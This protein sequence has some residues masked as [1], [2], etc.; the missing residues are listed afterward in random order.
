M[1]TILVHF[2]MSIVGLLTSYLKQE[3]HARKNTGKMKAMEEYRLTENKCKQ[4]PALF[5][6]AILAN[7]IK[8]KN[9]NYS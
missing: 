7:I 5:Y 9:H 4:I 6:V 3:L 8:S 1:L 2:A